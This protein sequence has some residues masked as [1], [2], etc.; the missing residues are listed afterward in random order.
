MISSEK[1]IDNEINNSIDLEN[2]NSNSENILQNDLF[3]FQKLKNKTTELESESNQLRQEIYQLKEINNHLITE[4]QNLSTLLKTY[5]AKETLFLL[6]QEN[7]TKLKEEYESL[8]ALLLEERSKHQFELRL[9]D[10]IYDHD[11]VQSNKR[12]DSLKNQIDMLSSIKKLND[13]LYYKNG[14][15]KQNLAS[16]KEEEKSKLEEMEIKYNKK[17]DNFKKKM[18]DFLKR[19]EEERLK[20]GTQT[21]LNNKL[22]ILH[23]QELINDLEIQGVEVEDLLKERQELKMKIR[24]LNNDLF[25]YQEVIDTMTKKNHRFQNKLKKISSNIKEYNLLS[26]KNY[27]SPQILTEPNEKS[28][29]INEL[30]KYNKKRNNNSNNI[31]ILQLVENKHNSQDSSKKSGNSFLK[32]APIIKLIKPK[33]ENKMIKIKINDYED[34]SN[35]K[36]NEYNS[37]NKNKDIKKSYEILF[38]EKEKYRDLYE[39]FKD[40]LDLIKKKY[41]SIF[42]MY[43]EILEK[44]YNE[45]IINK[46]KEDISININ[47]FKEF[48]FENMTSEQKYAVL[49]KLINNIAP[50]VYKKDLE[51]NLLIQNI[52]KVKEKYNFTGLNSM[53][54]INYSSQNSTK[55]PSGPVSLINFK[56]KTSNFN[57]SFR[58]NTTILGGGIKTNKSLNSFED[59][60][61]IFGKQKDQANKSLLHF[62]NSKI[63]IDLLPKINLLE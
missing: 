6:T 21:E 13:I 35:N 39:F 14:E 42:N 40:K 57:D 31:S 36:I 54:S 45:E 8:K 4:N 62:G 37:R 63:D 51:N 61:K 2:I 22:N 55:V 49:I 11:V 48:K 47:D 44:I 20:M 50:L 7:L 19:N 43:S 41:T 38:Q 30:K 12:S 58:T 1:K 34:N 24:K 5:R 59:F 28:L 25:I 9:K 32:N 16:L 23:I 26:N 27:N 18:I 46:N 29:S 60:K 52:S 33:K 15:L 3:L 17:I 56:A 53:N 10:S